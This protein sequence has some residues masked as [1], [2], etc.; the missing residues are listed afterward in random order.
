MRSAILVLVLGLAACDPVASDLLQDP[1]VIPPPLPPG[2]TARADLVARGSALVFPGAIFTGTVERGVLLHTR[3][4]PV[5][6][7]CHYSWDQQAIAIANV[8]AACPSCDWAFEVEETNP[9]DALLANQGVPSGCSSPSS[10]TT[11]TLAYSPTYGALMKA[12]PGGLLAVY[13]Y[14]V[15]YTPLQTVHVE[16]LTWRASLGSR[17][18]Y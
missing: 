9:V 6:V 18:Y 13:S 2:A 5:Q 3:R 15:S 11:G 10:S 1:A 8:A 14:D 16:N 17:Y 12:P 7:I 4:H